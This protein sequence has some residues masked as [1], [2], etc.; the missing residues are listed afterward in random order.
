MAWQLDLYIILLFCGAVVSGA[1]ASAAWKRPVA[2]GGRNLAIL[3]AS[4]FV[5]SLT[6][7]I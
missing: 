3:M 2:A 6:A 4:V 1:V 7:A 5:W